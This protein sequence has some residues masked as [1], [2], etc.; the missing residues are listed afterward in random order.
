[1]SLD[2]WEHKSQISLSKNNFMISLNISYITSSLII[3][4]YIYKWLYVCV[5]VFLLYIFYFIYIMYYI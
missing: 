3:L 5:F 1:M 4:L 2:K